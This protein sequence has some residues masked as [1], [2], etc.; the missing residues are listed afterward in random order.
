MPG[1][2]YRLT[3]EGELTDDSALAFDGMTVRRGDGMTVLIGP[4]RDQSELQGIL[5]RL[6]DMGLTLLSATAIS[7]AKAHGAREVGRKTPRPGFL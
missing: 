2:A 1:L 7:Q 5:Q 6:S 4:V 3:V